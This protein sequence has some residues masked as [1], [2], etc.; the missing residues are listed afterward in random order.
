MKKLIEVRNLYFGFGNA[1][2]LED[3]NID[4]YEGD[5]ILMMGPNGGGKTTLLKLITGILKPWRGEINIHPAIKNRLGY[6]PQFSDFNRSFPISVLDMV[7]TGCIGRGNY[8][9]RYTGADRDKAAAILERLNLV[10][11]RNENINSLSGGEVQRLLI[12]RALVSDPAV[13][14][15][16]EPTTSID[17]PSQS[18]LVDLL[19]DLHR[20]MTIVIVTHDPTPFAGIYKH[21]ACVNR[22]LHYHNRGELE[23]GHLEDVYGCPVELLGHGIPHVLLNRH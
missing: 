11:K 23:A 22:S 19:N 14:L 10:E 17:Q 21:V 1:P 7:L 6:V 2:L 16:D 3:I 15:L 18:T 20:D 13:L 4:I 9:K 12:S 8:L 5:Y